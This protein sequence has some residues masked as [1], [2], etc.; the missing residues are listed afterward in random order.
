MSILT[1]N[2]ADFTQSYIY[3]QARNTNSLQVQPRT[4]TM[5]TSKR[6]EIW[7]LTSVSPAVWSEVDLN[8]RDNDGNSV[9]MKVCWRNWDN[10]DIQLRTTATCVTIPAA[11]ALRATR[12][13]V[14]ILLDAGADTTI[15]NKDGD[16][17][18][19]IAAIN[20]RY[21]VLDYLLDRLNVRDAIYRA[22][23]YAL[24]GACNCRCWRWYEPRDV[25]LDATCME[26]WR[27]SI[28]LR[29]ETSNQS[30]DRQVP[31][32]PRLIGLESEV[33]CE[34]QLAE[35]VAES[36]GQRR[37]MVYTDGI[38]STHR[39][40]LHKMA[41][42]LRVLGAR[43]PTTMQN[44]YGWGLD[45][46]HLGSPELR[47][48]GSELCTF[49]SQQYID[50]QLTVPSDNN[51]FFPQFLQESAL[52]FFFRRHSFHANRNRY[53]FC[54][55]LLSSL[56]RIEF[57]IARLN[58]LRKHAELYNA[59]ALRATVDLLYAANSMQLKEHVHWSRLLATVERIISFG[60][61]GWN[62][63]TLLHAAVVRRS[64]PSW[65]VRVDTTGEYTSHL[66]AET[67][68]LILDCDRSNT[69]L[70]AIDAN[71]STALVVAC[72]LASTTTRSP[73]PHNSDFDQAIYRGCNRTTG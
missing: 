42:L 10:S 29:A 21:E 14:E 67:V 26:Y 51:V 40:A 25:R 69:L 2:G 28:Q 59:G 15:R 4:E 8:Y 35:L 53:M 38:E 27:K 64:L 44:I 54:Q 39:I 65:S 46:M 55:L 45:M 62:G 41:V 24:L 32:P 52:F 70:D 68:G 57:T 17:V 71:S 1:R 5:S 72:S 19:R 73:P 23:M 12:D 49:I 3:V 22:D 58:E 7:R 13:L 43:H 6:V 66:L 36:V 30:P 16:D 34:S 60:I 20:C 18:I 31:P 11:A 9:L 33:N 47:A 50:Y 56:D 37:Q 63:Q 61:R 48:K